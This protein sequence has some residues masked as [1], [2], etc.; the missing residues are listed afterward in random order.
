MGELTYREQ[1]CKGQRGGGKARLD[2]LEI[3][4]LNYYWCSIFS[5]WEQSYKLWKRRYFL[6]LHRSD[7]QLNLFRVFFSFVIRIC[8][9]LNRVMKFLSRKSRSIT[10]S[11]RVNAREYTLYRYYY[12]V[13]YGCETSL[14][15]LRSDD[16]CRTHFP[17]ITLINV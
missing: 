1:S 12:S 6:C 7:S 8:I 10:N 2:R 11:F 9:V 15:Y 14:Y 3:I 5:V 17:R 16:T 13:V 4:T